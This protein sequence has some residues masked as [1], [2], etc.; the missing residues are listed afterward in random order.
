MA[1]QGLSH[2]LFSITLIFDYSYFQVTYYKVW[3]GRAKAETNQGQAWH[4]L[5]G[6]QSTH[7]AGANQ[8]QGQPGLDGAEIEKRK[9]E[10]RVDEAQAY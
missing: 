4:R 6:D 1:R 10:P 7:N 5:V 8:G 2:L 9:D 3:Q